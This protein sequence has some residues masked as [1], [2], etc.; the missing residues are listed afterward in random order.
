MNSLGTLVVII[1]VSAIGI[2]FLLKSANNDSYKEK[3]KKP[4]SPKNMIVLKTL[5]IPSNLL[6]K[7][8]EN[9]HQEQKRTK[10]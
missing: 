6:G 4:V 1:L 2:Y 7:I 5:F 8:I 10:Q 3:S 9:L